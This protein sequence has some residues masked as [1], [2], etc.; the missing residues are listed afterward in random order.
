MTTSHET[1]AA[2]RRRTF[3]G[4]TAAVLAAP[5]LAAP[6]IADAQTPFLSGGSILKLISGASPGSASDIIG[7]ILAQKLGPKLGVSVIVDNKAGASGIVAAQNVLAS[8]ADG[9]TLFIQSGAHTITPFLTKL[10]FDPIKDFSGISLLAETPNV[11]VVPA[12]SSFHNVKE[13]VDAAKAQPGKLNYASSGNGST[14][15]FAAEKFRLAAGIDAIHV[16]FKAALDAVTETAAGRVDWLFPGVISVVQLIHA[17]K[18]RA[19]AVSS[20]KRS[21]LLPNVPTLAEAGLPAAQYLSWVG[22]MA[23]SRTPRDVIQ[24]L[25]DAVASA[26]QSADVHERLL[27]VG[28][29]PR[30]TTPEEFDA[31]LRAEMTSNAAI[32]KAAGIARTI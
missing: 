21:S 28:A 4:R 20:P 2:L 23:R 18:L 12:S 11:L 1:G 17:G 31:L 24:Q 30:V 5:A 29:E 26:M 19:L 7:R 10:G 3:I 13:L 6:T 8:P 32:V 27:T 15:H 25:H 16:P 22:L 9:R 14:S